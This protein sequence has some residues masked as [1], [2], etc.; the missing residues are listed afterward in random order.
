MDSL[1]D[2]DPLVPVG[3]FSTKLGSSL[4]TNIINDSC[5]STK[6]NVNPVAHH[7]GSSVKVNRSYKMAPCTAAFFSDQRSCDCVQAG[8][9][10]Y[11]P[12]RAELSGTSSSK[13][14]PVGGP[15]SGIEQ[16]KLSSAGPRDQ[17]RTLQWKGGRI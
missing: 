11:V 12:A 14:F 10:D 16:T 7:R 4:Y 8:S 5:T 15:C 9:P 13:K 1:V 6:Q 2:E 17:L 3:L